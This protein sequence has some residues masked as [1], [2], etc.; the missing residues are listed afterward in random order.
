M[1]RI[2]SIGYG[3]NSTTNDMEF[4]VP[5]VT[6][7]ATAALSTA[8][9]RF[10]VNAFRSENAQAS[11]TNGT[12]VHDY[13]FVAADANGPYYFREYIYIVALPAANADIIQLRTSAGTSK[14][15]IRLNT[16]ATLTLRDSAGQ[17]GSASA[18]LSLNTWYIVELSYSNDVTLSL[19]ARVGI[20]DGTSSV[21]FASTAISINTGGIQRIRLGCG[22]S[23]TLYD[24]WYTD[25]AINDNTGG[26]QTSFPGVGAL[27]YLRP[28]AA[29]DNAAWTLG[30]TASS[31]WQGVSE[32]PPD[33]VTSYIESSTLNQKFHNNLD[34]TP[35]SMASDAAISVVQCGARF[36]VS[37]TTTPPTFQIQL[38]SQA[39]GTKQT[40]NIL[41]SSSSW[42]SNTT[43]S[44][45]NPPLTSYTDPQAGGAWTKALL[46]ATQLGA[47]VVTQPSTK[48]DRISAMW[49]IVD[50]VPTYAGGGSARVPLR[51]LLGV[52][53]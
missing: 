16:D 43:A 52:G 41:P 46:D 10:G 44:P 34:D 48:F 9:P 20:D 31:N 25:L 12:G 6:G 1:A 4:S 32:I 17:I 42:R 22:T 49:L 8:H 7:T 51:S 35:S 11:P 33:D 24:I 5:A 37:S 38:E 21:S 28:S 36:T 13:I 14:A 53:T 27:C 30:G 50:Y 23:T 39:S 3:L 40:A 26:S 19:D 2:N 47:E 45:W 18:A 29:G 15:S